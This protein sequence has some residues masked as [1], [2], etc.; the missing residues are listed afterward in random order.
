M[1]VIYCHVASHDHVIPA[2]AGISL[3][4][5]AARRSEIP[6]FA[7]MTE[8][9]AVQHFLIPHHDMPCG[10]E[11]TLSVAVSRDGDRLSLHY[12]VT[13]EVERLRYPEIVSVGR[14]DGLWKETCFEAFVRSGDDTGY[15]EFNF[16]PSRQWASYRFDDYRSG[17]REAPIEPAIL[18][19]K[20]EGQYRL[21]AMVELPGGNPWTLGI[22]A[23]IEEIDGRKSYWALAHPPGKP[24]FHHSDCFVLELP[25]AG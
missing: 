19:V 3:L 6:A 12:L 25:A 1:H 18:I 15:H 13:G 10:T 14:A 20:G 11:I 24:D 2:K 16:S 7:G 17:M 9:A 5:T 22:S 21:V 8:L 4:D 23:V